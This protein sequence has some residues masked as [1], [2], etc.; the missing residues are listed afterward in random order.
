[1]LKKLKDISLNY[2]LIVFL[3]FVGKMIILTPSF[4]DSIIVLVLASLYGYTQYLKRFQPYN[5]DK[6]VAKDL[7]EVKS[8]LSKMNFIK[9]TDQVKE[10]RYF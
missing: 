3:V 2:S 1:M 10:K 8:A 5:L 6:E 4:A 9:A 7:L